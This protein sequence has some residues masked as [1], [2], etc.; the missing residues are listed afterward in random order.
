MLPLDFAD[1]LIR[2]RIAKMDAPVWSPL[3]HTKSPKGTDTDWAPAE[4]SKSPKDISPVWAPIGKH[5]KSDQTNWPSERPNNGEH[6]PVFSPTNEKTIEP[7][8]APVTKPPNTPVPKDTMAPLLT[9]PT[10][11]QD[12]NTTSPITSSPSTLINDNTSIPVSIAPI[13]LINY[14]T[15]SPI[16]TA[17]ITLFDNTTSR[18]MTPSPVTS[19]NNTTTSPLTPEPVNLSPSSRSPTVSINKPAV[20]FINEAGS[21]NGSNF[22]EVAYSSFLKDRIQNYSYYLYDSDGKVLAGKKFEMENAK[23]FNGMSFTH[24]ILP[25]EVDDMEGAVLVDET[26]QSVLNFLTNGRTI[27]AIDGPAKDL[28]SIDISTFQ[29]RS[30]KVENHGMSMGLIGTGCQFASFSFASMSSTP[31]RINQ[32]QKIEGCDKGLF[33]NSSATE[34]GLEQNS[35][36]PQALIGDKDRISTGAIVAMSISSA[37]LAL[38]IIHI[39]RGASKK[40]SRH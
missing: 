34:G 35:V 5:N 39:F 22:I 21:F 24:S 36:S 29:S 28:T 12:N 6:A 37:I 23:S 15:S 17:P 25:I 2:H 14:T 9:V 40:K 33:S 38:V 16:T 11:I 31:G 20:V 3:Q 8:Q 30:K 32:N 13:N 7:I 27:K 4:N 1:R 10:D 18:P 26:S 19:I